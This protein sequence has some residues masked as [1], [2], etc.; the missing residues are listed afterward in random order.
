VTHGSGEVQSPIDFGWRTLPT[1]KV[2]RLTVRYGVTNGEIFNNGHTIEVETERSNVLTLNGVEYELQRFHFHSPSEH[3]FNGDGFGMEMH[4]VH[5]SAA[6]DT[7]VVGVFVKRAQTSGALAVV[8]ETLPAVGPKGHFRDECL[9]EHWFRSVADARGLRR[10]L[11]GPC[12]G[13]E[14]LLGGAEG[15]D[16]EHHH[17]WH[18]LV[19]DCAHHGCQTVGIS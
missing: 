8:F 14:R 16:R 3:R 10:R 4:L 17:H 6:G 2:R 12:P 19:C 18:G 11:R 9:N 7:A 13:V 1:S 15:R 5:K